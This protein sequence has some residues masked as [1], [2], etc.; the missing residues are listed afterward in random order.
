MPEQKA[1]ILAT[2]RR[3]LLAGKVREGR[4]LFQLAQELRTIRYC[5]NAGSGSG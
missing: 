3:M 4:V 1:R 5:P 2:A